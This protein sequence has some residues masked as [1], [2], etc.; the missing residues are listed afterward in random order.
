MSHV[1]EAVSKEQQFDAWLAL[2]RQVPPP[3]EPVRLPMLSGS[4]MPAI[5][6]GHILLI[7]LCSADSCRVGDVVVYQDCERLVA[8]RLLSAGLIPWWL[9]KGDANPTGRWRHKSRILGRVV[10]AA[11]PDDSGAAHSPTSVPV[12]AASRRH[13]TRNLVLAVPR[14]VRDLLF[15]RR[16]GPA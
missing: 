1:P 13:H 14:R 12:A 10:T 7:E 8:H 5:P 16:K 2:T 9:E 4:M 11:A 15:R 6:V 3:A